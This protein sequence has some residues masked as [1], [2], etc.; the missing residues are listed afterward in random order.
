MLSLVS[1]LW[2][3]RQAYEKKGK[4][5]MCLFSVGIEKNKPD[6]AA[7]FSPSWEVLAMTGD[8]LTLCWEVHVSS[9]IMSLW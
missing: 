6:F 2:P 5:Q 4:M 8:F 9:M 1:L 3:R 7:C